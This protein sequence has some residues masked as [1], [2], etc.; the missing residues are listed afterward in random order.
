MFGPLQE[1]DHETRFDH[2]RIA[3]DDWYRLRSLPVLL[4]DMQGGR[5]ILAFLLAL[6]LTMLP[7]SRVF[8][9]ANGETPAANEMVALQHHHCD[10]DAMPIDHGM[11]DRQLSADCAAKCANAYAVVFFGA[12]IPPPISGT[13]SSFVSNPFHSQPASPPFRPPRI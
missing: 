5:T 7:I 1:A 2:L 3:G 12:I 11:K 13:E 4:K 8:A 6:S 9:M 10:H